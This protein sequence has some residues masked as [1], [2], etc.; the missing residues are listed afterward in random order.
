MDRAQRLLEQQHTET[1][2]NISERLGYA[3][4]GGTVIAGIAL[5]DAAMVLGII[6]TIATFIVNWY[7]RHK[8]YQL[9][10]QRVE[11]GQ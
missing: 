3:A 1:V 11:R 2:A 7:Y 6:A 8:S 10:K 9:E 4:G 5:N